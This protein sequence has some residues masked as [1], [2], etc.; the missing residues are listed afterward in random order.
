MYEAAGE[1]E[2]AGEAWEAGADFESAVRCYREAG[3]AERLSLV[4]ERQGKLVE[5]ARVASDAEDEARAIRL[6]RRVPGSDP[7]YL[8]ACELLA[9]VLERAG[10]FDEAAEKLE[11]RIAL[12]APERAAPE[13]YDWLARLLDESGEATRAVQVLEALREERPDLPHIGTR[14]ESL[15]KKVSL[16][17]VTSPAGSTPAESTQLATGDARELRYELVER[18]GRGG[19]GVVF[20][21]LDRRLKREVAL[22][23]LPDELRDDAG[24]LELFFREAR[25]AAALNHPNIVTLF[26]ADEE[27]GHFFITMELLHGHTLAEILSHEAPLS[28]QNAA[29]VG[30][31]VA[32][33]LAYAHERR[34]IHRD[35]KPS[36][37]FVTRD[38]S[39]KIM[40][41]GLAKVVE[42]V[43]RAVTVVGGTPFYMA[44]EQAVG[45]PV[46]ARTDLYALGVTLFQTVTDTLPFE[47]GDV[48]YHHRNT[49][50]PDPRS[51]ADVPDVLAELILEMLEKLPDGR[52]ESAD[53]V[54]RRLYPLAQQD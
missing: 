23:R 22:K 44:P 9:Q 17:F 41:F 27:D 28:A 38:R 32:T 33:G 49:P 2:L 14:L 52:P 40:D 31:Q 21:A 39:V 29:W 13:L 34:I 18:I 54:A 12:A 10:H 16:E 45:E 26:D 19:M 1:I 30:L 35:I 50:P 7:D 3:D 4:L 11:E 51:R 42:E 47:D 37:L 5:A 43:R 46:D 24:R 48:A 25:A 8:G 20:R 53:V 36:N 15:R 6:L